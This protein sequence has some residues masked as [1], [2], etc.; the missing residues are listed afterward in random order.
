MKDSHLSLF[1]K[2]I[3]TDSFYF[4]IHPEN[5]GFMS[6]GLNEQYLMLSTLRK[7]GS[8]D[9]K[10]VLCSHPNAIKWGKELFDHYMR[11]SIRINEI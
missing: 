6:L 7:D 8:F 11:N 4:Y 3:D 2:L 10:Y 1:A 9:N 5:L